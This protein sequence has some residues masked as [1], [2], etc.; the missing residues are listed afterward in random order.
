MNSIAPVHVSSVSLARPAE[1]GEASRAADAEPLVRGPSTDPATAAVEILLVNA[2]LESYYAGLYDERA[3]RPDA[4]PRGVEIDR[5]EMIEQ[6]FDHLREL[7]E[8]ISEAAA[9]DLLPSTD[10]RL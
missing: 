4:T 10:I 2:A 7:I 6:G 9:E 3:L 8:A 5:I 1:G